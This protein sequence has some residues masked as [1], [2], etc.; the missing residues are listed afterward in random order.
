VL[1]FQS[2]AEQ[3]IAQWAQTNDLAANGADDDDIDAVADE[4]A[5]ATAPG[6]RRYSRRVFHSSSSGEEVLVEHHVYGT[7]HAWS[8]GPKEARFTDPGGA[9]RRGADRRALRAPPDAARA[10]ALA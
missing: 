8:G 2:C 7:G 4:V 5:E 3:V 1:V 6:G 9:G 10:S